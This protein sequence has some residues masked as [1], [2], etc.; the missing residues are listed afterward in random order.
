[1]TAAPPG[2]QAHVSGS[3]LPF[4]ISKGSHNESMDQEHRHNGWGSVC[5][6]RYGNAQTITN[7]G[8]RNIP[9]FIVLAHELIHALHCLKGIAERNGTKEENWTRGVGSYADSA[10]TENTLRVAFGLAR[11]TDIKSS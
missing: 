1:M 4:W 5:T 3:G 9:P 11:R 2:H 10:L 6:L 7:T 8:E